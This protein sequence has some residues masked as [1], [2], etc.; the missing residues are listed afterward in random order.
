MELQVI[1]NKHEDGHIV[2]TE[3]AVCKDY[4]ISNIK[5]KIG[6]VIKKCVK[7]CILANKKTA[8]QEGFLN[9]IGKDKNPLQTFHVDHIKAV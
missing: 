4:Y 3:F 8:K 7:K 9:P 2:K 5:S 1:L 6:N